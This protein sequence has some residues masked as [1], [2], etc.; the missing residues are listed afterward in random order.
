MAL[1]PAVEPLLLEVKQYK[2]TAEIQFPPCPTESLILQILNHVHLHDIPIVR[3]VATAPDFLEFLHSRL[4]DS[5]FGD[6]L[7][8]ENAVVGVV[9]ALEGVGVPVVGVSVEGDVL[10][11]TQ[12]LQQAGGLVLDAQAAVGLGK[13]LSQPVYALVEGAPLVAHSNIDIISRPSRGRS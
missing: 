12:K 11:L 6:V 1:G 5:S 9:G 8:D 2:V 4:V 10:V 3:S 13:G 7:S